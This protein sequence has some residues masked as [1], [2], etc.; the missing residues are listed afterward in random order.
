MSNDKEPIFMKHFFSYVWLIP[1]M[2]TVILTSCRSSRKATTEDVT[3]N[4]NTTEVTTIDGTGKTSNPAVTPT[5]PKAS[6]HSTAALNKMAPN[7]QTTKGMRAKINVAMLSGSKMSASGTLK[8]KRD[9]II[10][11]SLSA[12]L[13]MMEVGRLELT[14]EYLLIQD[15]INHQYVQAMWEGVPYLRN[16][17]VNFYTFQSL[18]W[19]E[20]FVPGKN[21]APEAYEFNTEKNH[22]DF[23]LSPITQT[24]NNQALVKF[25]VD[26][27]T[28]LLKQTSVASTDPSTAIGIDWN[29]G[30]WSDLAGKQFPTQMVMNLNSNTGNTSAQFTLSRLQVDETMGDIRTQIDTNRYT[31]VNLYRVFNRLFK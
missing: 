19:D 29:Y 20:L 25:L 26:A 24:E 2:T 5:T 16:A 17:G 28:G 9:E 30:E 13:G 12:I 10:Q 1:L 6:K 31:Q 4:T 7:L 3:S 21:S 11:I 22:N 27:T 15:R 18:F 14:P 23:I 8:M